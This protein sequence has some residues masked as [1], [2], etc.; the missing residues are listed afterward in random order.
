ML[1]MTESEMHRIN[2][3]M[4]QG[5]RTGAPNYPSDVTVKVKGRFIKMQTPDGVDIP[6]RE[7]K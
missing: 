7:V 6:R 5:L 3:G 1:S 4:K 2:R